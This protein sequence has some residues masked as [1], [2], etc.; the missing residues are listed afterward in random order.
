MKHY[1]TSAD[2]PIRVLLVDDHRVVLWGLEKLINGE[3]PRM[4]VVGKATTMAETLQILKSAAPDIVLLDLK[5]NG[6]SGLNVMPGILAGSRAKV[7]VLTGSQDPMMHDSAVLAG[8]RG[9][10]EKGE[11]AEV[12]IK[13]I[14]RVHEGELWLDRNATGRIFVEMARRQESQVHDPEQQR[15]SSLTRK[16]RLI[17]TS[18]ASNASTSGKQVAERLHISEHTLR[19]HLTSIYAKLCVRNRLELFDYATKN[20]ILKQPGE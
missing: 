4:E 15:I 1:S 20:R 5:L 16:E 3:R 17:V 11:A 8:A 14:E 6:E 2:R 13:A 12:L 19:N 9:V 7:L 18:I 10:V